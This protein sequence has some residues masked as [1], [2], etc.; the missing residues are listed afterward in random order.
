MNYFLEQN[1]STL[2]CH[3]CLRSLYLTTNHEGVTHHIEWNWKNLVILT[4]L[5]ERCSV[6]D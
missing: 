2:Q 3:G 4:W 6:C 5:D 1:S